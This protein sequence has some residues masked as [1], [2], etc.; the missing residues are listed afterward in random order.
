VTIRDGYG[1]MVNGLNESSIVVSCPDTPSAVTSQFVNSYGQ[2]GSAVTG[3][4]L[5]GIPGSTFQIQFTVGARDLPEPLI[6]LANITVSKCGA[7]EVRSRAPGLL[8][9]EQ[10]PI[11]R[12]ADGICLVRLFCAQVPSPLTGQC[13][14]DEG[15][16]RS[17]S[18]GVC[19]CS[20]GFYAFTVLA[21]GASNVRCE[22]CPVV[23]AM[24]T[25]GLL[26]VADG[27]WH[28]R[29]DRR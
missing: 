23:G 16:E 11:V 21:N 22:P 17:T 3:L 26:V 18:G 24:C 4:A 29:C 20:S 2:S 6:A 8:S 19:R 27:F 14:C 28:S 5:N 25:N 1:Q 9:A 15:S 13:A 10:S 12:A 7:L